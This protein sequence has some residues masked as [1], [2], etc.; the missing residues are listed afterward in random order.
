MGG[1]LIEVFCDA[2]CDRTGYTIKIKAIG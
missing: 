2:G 1:D